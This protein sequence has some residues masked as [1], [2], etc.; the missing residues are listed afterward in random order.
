MNY[1][2]CTTVHNCDVILWLNA[3]RTCTD[4]LRRYSS[5]MGCNTM[6]SRGLHPAVAQDSVRKLNLRS[7]NGWTVAFGDPGGGTTTGSGGGT[8]KAA[9][10]ARKATDGGRSVADGGEAARN[11]SAEQHL[12]RQRAIDEADRLRARARKELGHLPFTSCTPPRPPPCQRESRVHQ[13]CILSWNENP[14]CRTGPAP[15]HETNNR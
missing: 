12:T 4:N 8:K 7:G 5:T 2:A 6:H 9:D 15:S 1:H 3:T 10:G 14:P 13:S 11:G